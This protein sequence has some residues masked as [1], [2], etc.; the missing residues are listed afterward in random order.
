MGR[1]GS[2][3][4]AVAAIAR[5]LTVAIWYLMNGRWTQLGEINKRLSIKVGKIIT[6]VGKA[7]LQCLGATRQQLRTRICES[8][9]TAR[10]YVLDPH[11]K[12]TPK[13]QRP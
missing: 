2:V 10:T 1:K 9:T 8:L 12:F 3:K 6:M 4:L 5:K 11:K 13:P 7:P